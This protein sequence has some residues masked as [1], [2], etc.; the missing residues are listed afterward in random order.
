MAAVAVLAACTNGGHTTHPR[1]TAPPT[2]I[3][4]LP[5]ADRIR[6]GQARLG[7]PASCIDDAYCAA[8]I[9]RVYGLSLGPRIVS[10]ATPD[11]TLAALEAGSVDI[12]V[13]PT[14]STQLSDPHLT[15]LVDDRGLLPATNLVPI[16]SADLVRTA[17]S[18]L[19]ATVDEVS[20]ELTPGGLATIEQ[21]RGNGQSPDAAARSWLQNHVAA[22]VPGPAAAGAPP[23]VIGTRADDQSA[24]IASVYAGALARYGWRTSTVPVGGD[25]PEELDALASGRVG[26]VIDEASP[27]LEQLTGFSG[28]STPDADQTVSL[29]RRQLADLNLV[30]FAPSP[31]RPGVAFAVS[32]AVAAALG[33][34]TLSDLARASGAHI[35]PAPTTTTTTT[36]SGT[37]PHSGGTAPARDA[38]GP[39]ISPVATLG[40]GDTGQA[41][42]ALQNRLNVLGYDRSSPSGLFDETTR[43][44]VVSFQIDSNLIDTGELDA[45]TGRAL[46]SAHP[47]AHPAAVPAPG[48]PASL[49]PPPTGGTG[50]TSSPAGTVYL[51]FA[52]GPSPVTA[53]ILE[54]LRAHHATA[55]FFTDALA[56][57]RDPDPVRLEAAAGNGVGV[58]ELPHD[59]S[60]P[61]AGD[62]MFRT[63]DRTQEALA[64][65]LSRTPT[66]LLAPYGATDAASRQR[67]QQLGLRVVLSDVDPQ[68]W[69]KPGADAIAADVASSARAGAVVLLHDGGGDRAQTVVAVAKVLDTLTARGFGFAAIPDC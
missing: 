57:A 16:V 13:L 22:A 4:V 14:A 21:A 7:G 31:A 2:T 43:R 39:P 47:A 26:L 63:A 62:V 65:L 37:P 32:R 50:A 17:G 24:A 41:V 48:D 29:L 60:S 35:P 38:E 61:I 51:A 59:G 6:L 1:P 53:Q 64:P 12:G 42:V 49:R 44:A 3:S 69:R 23:I 46:A 9:S 18:S 25:R 11:A 5:S 45:A 58:S 34:N 40:I 33:V 10:L 55:T 30:A 20:A 68:D 36:L 28:E 56:L 67:A 27:L 8:G 54:L 52:S 15:T 66:C 19:A